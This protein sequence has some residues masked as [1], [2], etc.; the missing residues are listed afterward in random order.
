MRIKTADGEADGNI[1]RG[2]YSSSATPLTSVYSRT[3]APKC[4]A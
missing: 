1:V 3:E 4:I 2:N